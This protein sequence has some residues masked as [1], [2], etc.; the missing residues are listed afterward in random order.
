LING[1]DFYKS[2]LTTLEKAIPITAQMEDKIF[3]ASKNRSPF[4]FVEKVIG[5]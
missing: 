2:L 3:W 1:S 4:E 5:K